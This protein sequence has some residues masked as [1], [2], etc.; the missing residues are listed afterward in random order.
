MKK[1]LAIDGGGIKGVFPAAFLASVEKSVGK[2]IGEYFDLIVGTSTG[3]IIA[4][5]LGLGLTAEQIL[6]FY[7]EYGPAIFKGN[8]FLRL[9]RQLGYSKYNSD[10]LEAA[11]QETFGNRKIGESTTRLVIP[12]LNLET[13]EVHVYK[14]AHH[15]RFVMDYKLTAKEAALA[16]AAAPT[17][18]PT[19]RS[20]AGIPLIDGGMW[21]NNP[22]GAAA[23]EALGVLDWKKGDIKLLSIGCTTEP[24]NAHANRTKGLGVNYWA[25]KIITTMMVGQSSASHGTAQLLLGHANVTRIS[26]VVPNKRFKLDATHDL[27]SLKGLGN[28][29]ARK[30]LPLIKDFFQ[31]KATK[32]KPNHEISKSQQEPQS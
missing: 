30:A 29:E 24:L 1:I 23:V 10:A 22:A 31:D 13:G 17:Y 9:L 26:P 12:S 19:Y 27:S 5:G 11:L 28:S 6:G 3:G 2:P 16:T 21:A 7:E 32:F 20:A 15:E 18:F 25:T 14:T 8:K 4:L